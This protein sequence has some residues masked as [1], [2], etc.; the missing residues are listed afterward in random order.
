MVKVIPLRP[1]DR[2]PSHKEALV[3]IQMICAGTVGGANI[4]ALEEIGRIAAKALSE[5]YAR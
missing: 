5:D 3:Q 1:A 2:P 4:P